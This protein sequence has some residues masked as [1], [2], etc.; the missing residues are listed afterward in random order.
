MR[1]TLALVL[2]GAGLAVFAWQTLQPMQEARQTA[3]AQERLLA[4]LPAVATP[5]HARPAGVPVARPAPV[6]GALAVVRIPRFGADWKWAA[7]EGTALEQI[8]SGPGHYRGTPLPGDVGNVAFAAHRAGHGDPFIDFDRFEPGD[9]VIFEQAGLRWTYV[10]DTR[11]VIIPATASWVLG[12][13]IQRQLTLTTCWPRY[14]SSKR[15]FVRGHLDEVVA[16]DRN[17]RW[18]PVWTAPLDT[19]QASSVRAVR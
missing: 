2:I 12:P 5:S 8:N 4:D 14:G 11:P 18:Q 13:S 7:V 16:E 15:M 19:P 10:I 9:D 6:G 1:R 3:A 17:Q